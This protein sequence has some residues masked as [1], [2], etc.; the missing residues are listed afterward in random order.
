[1]TAGTGE[2]Y[3]A[4]A[5][6]DDSA[7]PRRRLVATWALVFVLLLVGFAATIIALNITLYSASGFVG[8]YLSALERRD[9]TGALDTAGV[10]LP[11]DDSPELLV[12]DATGGLTDIQL[13]D[14]IDEGAG[15]HR[16]TMEFT[17]NG[18]P[19]TS[20]FLVER[21]GARFGLF[22]AWRF[23]QSPVSTLRIT[24]LGASQFDA[25]DVSVTSAAGPSAPVDYAVLAP[26]VVTLSHESDLLVAPP[27]DIL[28]ID[29]GATSEVDVRVEANEQFVDLV[30]QE[31]NGI[32]DECT[33]QEVLQPTG[34]PFGEQIRNRVDGTPEWSMTAYP[35]VRIVRGTTPGTFEVPQT[36]GTAHLVVGVRSLFDG[37]RSTFDEDVP[38]T[39]SYVITLLPDGQ[40]SIAAG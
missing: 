21:D 27:E 33:T 7:D 17:L 31:L 11:G 36:E 26:G 3:S 12:P 19:G 32:L 14:D 34:C 37:T 22:S 1:M 30:Q 9:V 38:F 6:D 13:A 25:N 39:V 35:D 5:I 2:E 20:E 10:T 23:A 4:R 28:V 40:V 18:T 15:T 24:P 29:P 16:V 8:S